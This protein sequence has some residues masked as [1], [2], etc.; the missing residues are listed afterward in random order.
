MEQL[1]V[2]VYRITS[3]VQRSSLLARY[4]ADK[5]EQFS[6]RE[7]IRISGLDIPD[8]AD[9]IAR[10]EQV[11]KLAGE[12]GVEL[13]K[14]DIVPGGGGGGGTHCVR[15]TGVCRSNRSFF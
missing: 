12:V 1:N 2:K 5:L 4:E 9:T 11:C 14:K 3:I 6:R 15:H 7:S 13:S 10:V 8:E